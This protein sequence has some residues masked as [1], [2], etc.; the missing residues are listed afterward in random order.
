[1]GIAGFLLFFLA[2]YLNK[3][4]YFIHAKYKPD[5]DKFLIQKEL[6]KAEKSLVSILNVFPLKLT[7]IARRHDIFLLIIFIL[8]IFILIQQ[9]FGFGSCLFG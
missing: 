1:L 2:R 6:R 7:A 5:K 4:R 8:S 3:I 9:Q